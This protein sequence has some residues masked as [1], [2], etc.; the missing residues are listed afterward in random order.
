MRKSCLTRN[1]WTRKRPFISNDLRSY[2][3][4]PQPYEVGVVDF[5]AEKW[6]FGSDARHGEQYFFKGWPNPDRLFPLTNPVGRVT[7]AKDNDIYTYVYSDEFR[8]V[9]FLCDGYYFTIYIIYFSIC[10]SLKPSMY[11]KIVFDA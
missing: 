11:A 9:A 8:V 6:D 7:R 5:G 1:L 10:I 3:I 4:W 2:Q